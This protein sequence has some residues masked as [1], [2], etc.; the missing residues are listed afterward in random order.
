MREV[1][2]AG[3]EIKLPAVTPPPLLE[4]PAYDAHRS[5]HVDARRPDGDH[6]ERARAGSCV[7][8]AGARRGVA[9]SWQARRPAGLAAV[10]RDPERW[11]AEIEALRAYGHIEEAAR[12]RTPRSGRPGWIEKNHPQ[13]R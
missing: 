9:L 5:S 10:P 3:R 7:R 6:H 2:S 4:L 12:S 1:Q 8:R 11:Y 13:N